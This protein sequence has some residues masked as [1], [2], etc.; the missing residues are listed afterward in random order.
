MFLLIKN[1]FICLYIYLS[2]YL[3]IYLGCDAMVPE[4]GSPAGDQLRHAGRLVELRLYLCRTFYQKTTLPRPIWGTTLYNVFFLFSPI[5]LKVNF[6]TIFV[7]TTR[8]LF[9]C[10][11]S[12]LYR[13]YISLNISIYPSFY[14]HI[15]LVWPILTIFLYVF[16][17]L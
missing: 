8:N 12:N 1:V 14:T 5:H 17:N 16:I 15:Y 7:K 6:Y 13:I 11:T 3:S 9:F 10:L 2:I 4:P